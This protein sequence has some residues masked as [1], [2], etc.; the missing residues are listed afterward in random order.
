MLPGYRKKI[1]LEKTAFLSPLAK[2][3]RLAARAEKSKGGL[4]LKELKEAIKGEQGLGVHVPFTKKHKEYAATIGKKKDEL[5]EVAKKNVAAYKDR[6]SPF[7]GELAESAKT[8]KKLTGKQAKAV[9]KLTR[10]QGRA[11]Y[12]QSK[13]T[14]RRW[15]GSGNMR[16]NKRQRELQ[17]VSAKLTSARDRAGTIDRKTLDMLRS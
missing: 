3:E 5:K 16:V 6:V 8:V 1:I 15:L 2:L 17:D 13:G 10:A 12:L 7:A 4:K 9:R 11:A 14:I